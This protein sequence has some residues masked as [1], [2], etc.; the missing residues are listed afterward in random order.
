MPKLRI[1]ILLVV[2]FMTVIA[3]TI[4]DRVAAADDR[5]LTGSWM[6]FSGMPGDTGPP[7]KDDA[8]ILISIEGRPAAEMYRQLGPAGQ[9][10]NVCSDSDLQERR[11]GEVVCTRR[12]KSGEY[13]CYVGMD[14]RKGK[15]WGGTAC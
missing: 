10:N 14:L 12:I 6:V 2:S 15:V 9:E 7:T 8:K 13:A 5:R 4:P 3:A 1:A 11:R